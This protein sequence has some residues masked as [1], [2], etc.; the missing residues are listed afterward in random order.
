MVEH[1]DRHVQLLAALR[2]PHE[3]GDRCVHRQGDVLLTAELPEALGKRVVHP[4]S[5]LEVDLAR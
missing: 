4:E 1:A 5:T 3:A 2:V